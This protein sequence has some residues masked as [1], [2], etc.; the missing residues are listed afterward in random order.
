MTCARMVG[1]IVLAVLCASHCMRAGHSRHNDAY[2][3]VR[4]YPHGP[5]AFTQG[6]V[7]VDGYLYESTGQYGMSSI[8]RVDL[9]TGRILQHYD[10]DPEYFG[11]GLTSWGNDLIQLTWKAGLGFVYDRFSFA[12]KRSFRY[13]G[14]GW[15][16]THDGKQ[17]ILSDG[18]SILRFLD[19][20]SYLETKRICV[21]DEDERPLSKINELEYVHGEI[22]ANVWHSDQIVRISPRT[23]R[24]LGRIDLSG[25]ISRS[26]LANPRAVLNG[27]AYDPKTGRLFVT[28]KLWPELF[29]IKIIRQKR[30]DPRISHKFKN[31]PTILNCS[32]KIVK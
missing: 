5:S 30:Q 15:G 12:P 25:L 7:Y 27:I 20:T 11:E 18:T 31:V 19:P 13:Q 32:P 21:T 8:R 17:L 2:Q 29:E 23:G 3:V 28:G 14:E 26:Q 22:Y 4:S 6:L 9:E 1:V 10:L 24:I 16:L